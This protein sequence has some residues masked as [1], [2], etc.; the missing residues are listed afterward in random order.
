MRRRLRIM[1]VYED[2]LFVLGL[3]RGLELWDKEKLMLLFRDVFYRITTSC[4]HVKL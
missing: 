4:V 1:T 2:S 3:A